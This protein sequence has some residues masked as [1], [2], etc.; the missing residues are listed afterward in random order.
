[1]KN[2]VTFKQVYF[3]EVDL[4]PLRRL[5]PFLAAGYARLTAVFLASINLPDRRYKDHRIVSLDI[6]FL[7]PPLT[8]FP[9]QVPNYT[10]RVETFYKICTKN[11]VLLGIIKKNKNYHCI[12]EKNSVHKEQFI[13]NNF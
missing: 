5:Y 3:I 9:S 1:M 13:T 2:L 10:D 6:F 12:V 8:Y 7:P 4:S 11:I